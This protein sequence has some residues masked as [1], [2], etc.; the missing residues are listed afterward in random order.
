VTGIVESAMLAMPSRS[1]TASG[2]LLFMIVVVVAVVFLQWVEGS[3]VRC[4]RFD[5]CGSVVVGFDNNDWAL[6]TIIVVGQE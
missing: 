4:C 5:R 2:F 1:P 6:V 3:I